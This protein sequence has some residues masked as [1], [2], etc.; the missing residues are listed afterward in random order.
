[1]I[2]PKDFVPATSVR[3]KSYCQPA[4]KSYFRLVIKELL[5]ASEEALHPVGKKELLPAGKIR[6][7][8]GR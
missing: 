8:S 1:M 2:P 3:Q 4:K 7:T 6:A 5:P